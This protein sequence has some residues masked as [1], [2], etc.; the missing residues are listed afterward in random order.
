[1]GSVGLLHGHQQLLDAALHEDDAE[2][3]PEHRAGRSDIEAKAPAVEL[4]TIA[5]LLPPDALAGVISCW[6]A[7]PSK[8]MENSATG[9]V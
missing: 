1:M 3:A 6:L 8:E 9:T 7:F 4:R 2:E 5:Q